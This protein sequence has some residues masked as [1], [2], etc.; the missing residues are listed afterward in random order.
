[1]RYVKMFERL[2]ANCEKPDDQNENGCWLWTGKTDHKRGGEYGRLNKRVD[3]KHKTV[4]AHREMEN[5]FREEQG[6]P[7][8]D[9]EET[10]D[11]YC[12]S[13]LCINPDH[14]GEPVSRVVNSARSQARNPRTPRGNGRLRAEEAQPADAA[15]WGDAEVDREQQ[16][17]EV[18]RAGG[19]ECTAVG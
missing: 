4:A 6:L 11:H 9:P 7:P 13:G 10:I 19:A 3:G 16:A 2:V 18:H 15:S 17:V 8:L 14:W 1:M 12:T 5:T